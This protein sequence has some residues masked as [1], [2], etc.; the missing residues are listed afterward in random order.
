[1]YRNRIECL[2]LPGGLEEVKYFEKM[3]DIILKY[4]MRLYNFKIRYKESLEETE[5]NHPRV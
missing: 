3:I 4:Q 1:M 2:N 5:C